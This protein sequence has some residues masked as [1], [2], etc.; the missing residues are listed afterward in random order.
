LAQPLA[1]PALGTNPGIMVTD[2]ATGKT[3]YSA[4]STTPR[5]PASTAKILTA[6]AIAAHTDLAGHRTTRVTRNKNTLTL[7]ADGDTLLARGHGNPYAT[8]GHAGLADLAERTAKALKNTPPPPGGWQLT[9]D[10]S[11]ASGPALA[12]EWET[13][14]VHA[15]LTAPVTML[16]LAEDRATPGHPTTHDP[17]MTATTAFRDALI[18]A[19]IPVAEP[20][21]R[22]PKNAHKGKHIASI[23]SA[24]I[25]DVLTLAL[26]ESDNALTESTARRA[27]ADRGIPA[28]FA[29][30]GKHIITTLKSLGLDTTHSHL[31]DASG[32]SRSSRVTVRL[33]N[34]ATTLAANKNHK[35]LTHILDNLPVA[36]LTGTLHDRFATPQTTTGRG[37]VRAKTGTLTG[38]GGLT[39]TL[40][41]NS[42]R[43]LT[44]TIL[45]DQA[46]PTTSLETRAALDYV[47]TTLVSCGCN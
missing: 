45:A 18:T 43:L 46:P 24:P 27:F 34:K 40:V 7:V 37:I 33:I 6:T 44:Y 35:Q 10:D 21:T 41:T 4:R 29:E 14:D 19:G 36:A 8:Q 1:A 42:G 31:A 2:A 11:T 3:L 25:G 5:T 28:T 26:A 9:L 13:A 38:I 16:G 20:I 23:A 47:A 12:P 30:A 22:T 39:G 15:G 17:A 32:L